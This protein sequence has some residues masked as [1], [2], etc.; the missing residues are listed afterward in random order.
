[1]VKKLNVGNG[2][3]Q[4]PQFVVDY[5]RRIW[6]AGL[7]AFTRAETEGSKLFEYLVTE[8][9]KFESS[10]RKV[11]SGKIEEMLGKVDAAKSKASDTWDRVENMFEDQLSGVLNR[12]GVPTTQDIEDLSKRVEA[13]HESIK[14][15]SKS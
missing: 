12:L 2:K 9:E 8:G 7:G 1:M 10:T 14:S 11:A 5:A 13:L 15:L 3:E 4:R 6:L